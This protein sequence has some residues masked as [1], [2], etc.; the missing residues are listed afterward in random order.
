MENLDHVDRLLIDIEDR[1]CLQMNRQY[2]QQLIDVV[3]LEHLEHVRARDRKE[4]LHL[5]D[6]LFIIDAFGTKL[7]DGS[8]ALNLK[9]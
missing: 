4:M 7:L 3:V 8:L 6:S 9:I 1:L 2:R 5:D